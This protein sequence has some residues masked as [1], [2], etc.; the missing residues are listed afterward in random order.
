MQEFK[1]MMFVLICIFKR[2]NDCI[3]YLKMKKKNVHNLLIDSIKTKFK[4]DFYYLELKT[5][6]FLEN[7]WKNEFI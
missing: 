5:F 6:I 1:V 4:F 3:P 2:H 7:K